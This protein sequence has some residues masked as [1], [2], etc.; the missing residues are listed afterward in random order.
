MF[1]LHIYTYP[2]P[3]DQMTRRSYTP[4]PV[5]GVSAQPGSQALMII[6]TYMITEI[7][8]SVLMMIITMIIILILLILILMFMLLIQRIHMIIQQ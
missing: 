7:V 8:I 5:S 1:M 3:E 4:L 2:P 6:N